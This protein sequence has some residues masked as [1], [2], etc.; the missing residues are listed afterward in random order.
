MRHRPGR[1][2]FAKSTHGAAQHRNV[3][4]PFE[5]LLEVRGEVAEGSIPG[6]KASGHG[7]LS[8]LVRRRPRLRSQVDL[9][10]KGAASIIWSHPDPKMALLQDSPLLLA[11]KAAFDRR[12]I[13]LP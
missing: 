5:N 4:F 3:P 2:L 11:P 13:V 10:Q 12:Q 9:H 7:L 1:G 8:I 6:K